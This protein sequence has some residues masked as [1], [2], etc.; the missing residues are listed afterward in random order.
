MSI[1]GKTTLTSKTLSLQ[2]TERV[3]EILTKVVNEI[4]SNIETLVKEVL[5]IAEQLEEKKYLFFLHMRWGY[6]C[7][8]LEKYDKAEKHYLS[9]LQV[10]QKSQNNDFIAFA[11]NN[12]GLIYLRKNHYHKALQSLFRALSENSED[13]QASI[14]SNIGTVFFQQQKFEKALEYYQKVLEYSLASNLDNIFNAYINI[15]VGLQ[16]LNRYEEAVE[17]YLKSLEIM[18][19]NKQYAGQKA[20]CFENLGEARLAQKKYGESLTYLQTAL[21]F[22]MK[23]KQFKRVTTCLYLI[24]KNFFAQK[25]YKETYEYLQ[26]SLFY[27]REYSFLIEEKDTLLMLIQY[28]KETQ[29]WEDCI[30]YQDQLIELQSQYFYPEKKEEV[31]AILNKKEEEFDILAEKNLKIV[32]QNQRLQQYNRELKQYA[33]IVAH[34]LKEPL[35]NISGFTTLLSTKHKEQLSEEALEFL[36][37]IEGGAQYMHSLLEDLLQ[38]TTLQLQ[39][40][41]IVRLNTNQQLQ[42]V[43]SQLK[44]EISTA[45]AKIQVSELPALYIEPKHFKWLMI[46][47]LSNALKFI[48]PDKPCYVFVHSYEKKG[49]QYIEVRDNGIGIESVQQQKIFGIFQRLHKQNYEG[50]GIGLA[51]CKKIIDLY[52]G[53][54]GLHSKEN[55]G[56]AFYFSLP[57]IV[58]P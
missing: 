30:R 54:I 50:T 22:N 40:E 34:D 44:T 5:P 41:K 29:E 1:N 12:L 43:L 24:G 35:C 37:Y 4:P 11:Y 48:H 46:Q 19:E 38:Y 56:T 27:A 52:G 6:Y 36:K 3:L 58:I 45:N 55:E 21:D 28:Y 32:Q 25:K 39:E 53:E 51:I 57:T 20:A 13:L 33:F 42:T 31:Q 14:Y 47:I 10:A 26:K 15:G 16:S 2:K 49:K 9:A 7:H 17:Y 18:G 23:L 8:R